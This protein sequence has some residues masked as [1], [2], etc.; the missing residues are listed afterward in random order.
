VDVGTAAAGAWSSGI[1][2][3]F[4]AALL[5]LAGRWDWVT[6]PDWLQDPWVIAGAVALFLVELVVDKVAWLDSAWDAVHTVLRPIAGAAIFSAAGD[7]GTS[8][9]A[10][11]T[12]AVLA[13]S[14]HAAK[15][16]V[17]AVV[18]ASP[19]PVSN[20]VV[21]TTEDGLV[22]GLMALA[23]AFPGVALVVTIVLA[24]ASAATAVVVV[25]TARRL[26]LR[27][28]ARRLARRAE[29]AAARAGPAPP[30]G[31]PPAP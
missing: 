25:R 24:V 26:Q 10:V 4:V 16:S 9:A 17:R 30:S 2:M 14:A 15:A 12:G 8:L 31:P 27:L 13:L 11:A 3:Y 18:N 7:E 28:R 22:A 20:V 29:Q 6:S 23:I 19:E 1:S 21:S 5:G